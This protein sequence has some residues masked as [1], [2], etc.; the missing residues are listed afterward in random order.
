MRGDGDGNNGS[1]RVRAKRGVG[2][3]AAELIPLMGGSCRRAI[4]GTSRK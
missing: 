1:R 4:A 3:K 2:S